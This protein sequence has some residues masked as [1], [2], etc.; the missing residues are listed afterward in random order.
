M[1]KD[2]LLGATD[3]KAG[4]FELCHKGTLLDEISDMGLPTN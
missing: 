3:A 2:L 1:K 4:Q